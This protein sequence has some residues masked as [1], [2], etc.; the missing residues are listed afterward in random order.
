M[1]HLG[2]TCIFIKFFR[3]RITADDCLKHRW[4]QQLKNAAYE[5]SPE[6]TSD[7]TALDAA[8]QNLSTHKEHWDEQGCGYWHYYVINSKSQAYHRKYE[9]PSCIQRELMP[10]LTGDARLRVRPAEQNH[11]HRGFR[12]RGLP[13]RYPDSRGIA[14]TREGG[15]RSH[16][17]AI[18][19]PRN[20]ERDSTRCVDEYFKFV[21]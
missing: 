8:K 19:S 11:F 5:A 14:L 13:S 4:L 17:S 1:I 20:Q 10:D 18:D 21:I 12:A 9:T 6:F 3:K 15:G 2:N 7:D 16:S